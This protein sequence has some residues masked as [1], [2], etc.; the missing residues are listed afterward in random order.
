MR[1]RRA[2]IGQHIIAV[3]I[4]AI[5]ERV[6]RRHRV[7]CVRPSGVLLARRC[8]NAAPNVVRRASS[9]RGVT[10][11]EWINPIL[12]SSRAPLRVVA[13]DARGARAMPSSSTTSSTSSSCDDGNA[14]MTAYV[15]DTKDD[16]PH[17]RGRATYDD[18]STYDG[19]FAR[20]LRHGRGTLTMYASSSSEEDEEASEEA[21]A[22]E[23]E[24]MNRRRARRFGGAYAGEWRENLPHGAMEQISRD[25]C[26]LRGTFERGVLM[27]E[28][29]MTYEDGK[30]RRFV[31]AL[32]EES[33]AFHGVGCL[34]S[35]DGECL[36]A[37]FCDGEVV[38]GTIAM[39]QPSTGALD[40]V[41]GLTRDGARR[42]GPTT[43]STDEASRGASIIDTTE[44]IGVRLNA[45]Q[46]ND[47]RSYV[48]S[49]HERAR[50]GARL[51]I[52]ASTSTLTSPDVTA[53]LAERRDVFQR[54]RGVTYDAEGSGGVYATRGI[55]SGSLIAYYG[56]R[57]INIRGETLSD[58]EAERL[59]A[60][61]TMLRDIDANADAE[62]VA[63][64]DERAPYVASH[65]IRMI[66]HDTARNHRYPWLANFVRV[67]AKHETN[68]ERA[69]VRAHPIFGDTMCLRASRCIAKGEE[70][71]VA[72]DYHAGWCLDPHSEAGY[73]ESMRCCPSRVA[74]ERDAD[75]SN[76]GRVRVKA[77]KLWRA[78]YLDKVEQGLSY[79]DARTNAIVPHVL[80]F[81]YI[82]AMARATRECVTSR[83]WRGATTRVVAVGLGTGALPLYVKRCIKVPRSTRMDVVVVERS[84]A[85]IDAC[86]ALRVPMRVARLGEQS[87]RHTS[88]MDV[89][90]ADIVD[91]FSTP[92]SPRVSSPH[93][94]LLDAYDGQGRIPEH[95]RDE[96][97]M[98]SMATN[99]HRD[100]VVICNCWD[101]PPGSTA[102]NELE[103]FKQRLVRHVGPVRVARVEQQEHNVVLIAVARK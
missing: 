9:R 75:E 6:A 91:Y 14:V 32:D 7:L 81:Q 38:G 30:R 78:L 35:I 44:V 99:L 4:H 12:T 39:W 16:A 79:V 21:E 63:A 72:P 65:S 17:G 58:E 54:D 24:E 87:K 100:G 55:E 88:V 56:G 48:R 62:L 82:R 66:T 1:A 25:G 41:I 83:R 60:S 8:A 10:R 64:H 27:S 50:D 28:V 71:T 102:A 84:R 89:V 73:Y 77:H 52:V 5:R 97:F 96:R 80:G 40:G 15:G 11:I 90:C 92:R 98:R 49:L 13:A 47:A 76:L 31:G 93:V 36:T 86:R 101:G 46:A 18:G 22:C 23:D 20:G 74:Y 57:I 19:E 3:L 103:G 61:A 85:V 94:I 43:R 29:E 95:V 68:C 51:A 70:C 59:S 69:F 67:D 2:T 42:R 34:Y 26:I 45:E 37:E 53:G 33:G